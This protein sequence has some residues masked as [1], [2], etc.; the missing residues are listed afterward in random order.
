[1]DGFSFHPYPRRDTD[2][3][4]RGYSWPNV[5]F[6][7]LDRLKQALWDAFHDTPQPTTLEGLKLY[8]DEV[9]WQVDTSRR[10]GY[11][12][13][14]NVPVTDEITQAAIYG[15]LIRR[16]ACDADIAAVSFFGFRDDSARAGF[17]AALLRADGPPDPRRLRC[18]TPS[19]RRAR[20]APAPRCAGSPVTGVLDP[21]IE[22]GPAR[23]ETVA[24]ASSSGR[25]P[26]PS[27]A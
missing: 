15:D 23:A 25:T 17:Q 26:G 19:P 11:L 6:V 24:T 3:L 8:L 9:G 27:C 20:A 2:P 5:G 7:N 1:M 14:E 22:I 10:A 4:D 18:G 16:A 13:R 12:G 21:R